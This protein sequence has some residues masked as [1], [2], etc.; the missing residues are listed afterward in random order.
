MANRD[1]HD[2]WQFKEREPMD[3]FS[4]ILETEYWIVSII[5]GPKNATYDYLRYV[6]VE[7]KNDDEH[8]RSRQVYH[9]GYPLRADFIGSANDFPLAFYCERC[10]TKMSK[11]TFKKVSLVWNLLTLK[12]SMRTNRAGRHAGEMRLGGYEERD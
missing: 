2:G 8:Y 12:Y 5:K 11:K 10:R 7:C 3:T 1:L 6:E 9:L 4:A